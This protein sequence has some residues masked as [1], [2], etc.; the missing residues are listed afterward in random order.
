MTVPIPL[1]A[2]PDLLRGLSA[3]WLRCAD[4]IGTLDPGAIAARCGDHI[5]GSSSSEV[6]RSASDRLNAGINRTADRV[7]EMA[8][9]ARATAS[10]VHDAD[11]DFVAELRR[12]D[13]GR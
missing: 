11:E 4:S 12:I 1:Q 5:A 6:L 9:L 8:E 10:S 2:D 13:G 3:E 7:R